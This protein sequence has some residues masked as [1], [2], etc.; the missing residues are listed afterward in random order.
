VSEKLVRAIRSAIMLAFIFGVISGV[1]Y[2]RAVAFSL[3]PTMKPASFKG[4]A[5]WQIPIAYLADYISHA[6]IC[7][8][9]AFTVA[10]LVAEFI[11]KEAVA[12]HI[13]GK[14]SSAYITAVAMTPFLTVCSCTTIPLFS[15][16]LAI[17]IGLGPAMAFLLT[18][19]AANILTILLTGEILSWQLAVARMIF[20]I[21]AAVF[22]GVVVVNA[23][24]NKQTTEK[25]SSAK[26]LTSATIKTIKRPLDERL[27]NALKFGWYLAKTIFPALL[28]GIVAVSYFEAYMSEQLIAKYLTGVTGIMLA[29]VIGG[30][31]YTPALVEVV[32]TRGLMD[33]GM[34][35]A[36]ALS[37]LM[38]QPYDIPSMLGVSRIVGWRVVLTYAIFA[39][40]LSIT[41]G[42]TYGL[43]TGG[44]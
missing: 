4:L 17:G 23:P 36:A 3:A 22:I 12:K 34:S 40:I 6:W 24:W 42:L 39:L 41:A 15:G 32:L 19:P 20:S 21:I 10:G 13:S 38:G 25:Y 7:L 27:Y 5:W 31:L 28:I 14:K 16:I 44:L 37:F 33:L 8:L 9:F 2:S 18:A 26:I 30:P 35:Q 43:I 29:S 11:P 1:V